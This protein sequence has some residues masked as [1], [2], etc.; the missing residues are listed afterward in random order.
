M[1]V[2]VLITTATIGQFSQSL[3]SH[4]LEAGGAEHQTAGLKSEP[5]REKVSMDEEEIDSPVTYKSGVWGHFGF[6]K[7]D[8]LRNAICKMSCATT[9]QTGSATNFSSHP[10]RQHGVNVTERSQLQWLAPA[11]VLL[12]TQVSVFVSLRGVRVSF[13]HSSSSF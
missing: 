6:C 8:G 3:V 11:E 1:L 5:V 9:K 12:L 2:S 7:R 10:K 4:K 13:P